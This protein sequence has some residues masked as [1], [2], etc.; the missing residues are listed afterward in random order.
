MRIDFRLTPEGELYF[1]EANPNPD[2]EPDA[3]FASSAEAIGMRY[4]ELIQKLLSLGLRRG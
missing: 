1:L 2:V 3:E 4:G